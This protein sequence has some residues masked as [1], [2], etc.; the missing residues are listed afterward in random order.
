MCHVG[1]GQK[2]RLD[3]ATGSGS[4]KW[5]AATSELLFSHMGPMFAPVAGALNLRP[6]RRRLFSVRVRSNYIAP[7]EWIHR[8]A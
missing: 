6:L 8:A 1:V 3:S 4:A 7:L 5:F 2:I